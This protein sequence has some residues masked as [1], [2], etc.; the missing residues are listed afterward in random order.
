VNS[1]SDGDNLVYTQDEGSL[2]H[3]VTISLGECVAIW[4]WS[5]GNRIW[6]MRWETEYHEGGGRGRGVYQ[7]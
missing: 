3:A 2:L 1:L 5:P 6:A 7:S 4:N